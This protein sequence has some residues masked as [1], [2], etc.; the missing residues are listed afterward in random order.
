[1]AGRRK[2]TCRDYVLLGQPNSGGAIKHTCK[3]CSFSRLT[4]LFGATH[5][6]DHLVL[7]CAKTDQETK[8]TLAKVRKD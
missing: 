7:D 5:W 6:A 8:D 3:N 2:G 1:M 4:K